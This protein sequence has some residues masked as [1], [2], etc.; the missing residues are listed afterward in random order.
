M[1]PVISYL[2]LDNPEMK[3]VSGVKDS[4]DTKLPCHVC[5]V[6]REDSDNPSAK[7]E[8]RF[9]GESHAALK[10][11]VDAVYGDKGNK[12]VAVEA[13]S[14]NGSIS[15]FYDANMGVPEG[16]H[17]ALPADRTHHLFLGLV[18][19]VTTRLIDV[20]Y[21]HHHQLYLTGHANN[22]AKNEALDMINSRFNRIP[23]FIASDGLRYRNFPNGVTDL[24][25]LEAKDYAT[26]AQYWPYVWGTGNR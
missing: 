20:V 24:S 23:G 9:A 15:A 4:Q 13:L 18:K 6:P 16:I 22:S 17:G 26:I 8:F 12:L 25:L 1:F 2:I 11:Y 14:L 19:T 10:Q 7:Y 3:L 21:E 5:K